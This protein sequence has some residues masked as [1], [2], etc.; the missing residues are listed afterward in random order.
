M[1]KQDFKQNLKKSV[2]GLIEFTQVMVIN[3]LPKKVMFIIKTNCSYDGN[4]LIDDEEI[5]PEDKIGESSPINPAE[6]Q[7]VIDYL[8]RN[9]KVPEWINVQVDSC[10]EKNSYISLECCGRFTAS[11]NLLYHK[12][13]GRPPF[14]SLSPSIPFK[15]FDANTEELIRKIDLNELKRNK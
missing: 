6:E 7:M 3:K 1:D 13:E 11:E 2:E 8:W 9:G 14:H 15:Y 10:D 5:Y 4:E 12:N